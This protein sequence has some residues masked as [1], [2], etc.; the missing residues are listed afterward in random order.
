MSVNYINM[1]GMFCTFLIG[2]VLILK[3]IMNKSFNVSVEQAKKDSDKILRAAKADS[4]A[5]ISRIG[6]KKERFFLTLNSRVDIRKKRLEN[7]KNSLDFKEKAVVK[8]EL[9]VDNY[10]VKAMS[11]EKHINNVQNKINVQKSEVLNR[12]SAK[13]NISFETAKETILRGYDTSVVETFQRRLSDVEESF[14]DSAPRIAENVLKT[15]IQRLVSPTSVENHS[16]VINVKK[17]YI[18]AKIVGKNGQNI[19][20]LESLLDVAIVFNDSPN[21]ISISAFNL[22]LRRIA[23]KAIDRLVGYR[24]DINI[25][26]VR[27]VV[28]WAKRTVDKELYLIGK[29]ALNIMGIK[30]KGE[31]FTRIV[32]RLKY[33][34]SYGQNIMKHSMEVSWVAVMLASELGL[35]I[36]TCR[37]GGFLH[38]LGKAI[39]QN[40]DIEG[41]HDYLSK[42]LMEKYGFSEAEVHAAWTH[43]NAAPIETAEAMIVQ[44]ADAVSGGRPGARQDSLDRYIEKINAIEETIASFSGVKKS[45][46]MAAGREVRVYVDP[47]RIKDAEITALAKDLAMKIEDGVTY[48]GKIKVSIIRKTKVM[49]VAK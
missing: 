3:M 1:F 29:D 33:R 47:D 6:S 27:S 18:K 40:P 25:K 37:V 41:S 20:E 45:Y 46:I 19:M 28:E 12:L 5:I 10:R 26:T 9:V 21:T 24:G 2:G 22:V 44:A 34:T 32:G 38:D 39:D 7:F 42:V 30:G 48:P 35:N 31:E 4:T 17:D 8:R 16:V 49:D 14:K 43:H 11:V 15:V 13:V 23:E 36:D